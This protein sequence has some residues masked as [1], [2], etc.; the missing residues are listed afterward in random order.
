MQCISEYAI[1]SLNG[2]HYCNTIKHLLVNLKKMNHLAFSNHFKNLIDILSYAQKIQGNIFSLRSKAKLAQKLKSDFQLLKIDK[3]LAIPI[4]IFQHAMVLLI[5]CVG[6]DQHGKKVYQAT[7]YNTGLGVEHYHYSTYTYPRVVFQRGLEITEITEEKLCGKKS[8]FIKELIKLENSNL[9][10]DISTLYQ[11]ILPKLGNIMPASK[12]K[13]LWGRAQ[14]NSSCT[15]RSLFSLIKS[16]LPPEEY[17]AFK[18]FCLLENINKIY[19][20]VKKGCENSLLKRRVILEGIK[21]L[22]RINVK[23]KNNIPDHSFQ[24]LIKMKVDVTELFNVKQVDQHIN[25]NFLELSLEE[26]LKQLLKLVDNYFIT[27]KEFQ[28]AFFFLSAIENKINHQE[29]KIDKKQLINLTFF[30]IDKYEN[31]DLIKEQ[32]YFL[33]KIS[34]LIRKFFKESG[35]ELIQYKKFIQFSN[36]L[37]RDAH[38]LKLGALFDDSEFNEEIINKLA[39]LYNKNLLKLI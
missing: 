11:K 25:E 31:Q 24:E 30:I 22:E 17:L 2:A 14:V 23:Q 26:N 18:K 36:Q 8:L 28:N 21:R 15:V 27:E 1:T 35:N 4:T 20:R 34:L 3:S 33:A 10:K 5:T 7:H 38:F 19:L 32:I 29:K 12:N 39:L 16:Q 6:K 37:L 9:E 13:N